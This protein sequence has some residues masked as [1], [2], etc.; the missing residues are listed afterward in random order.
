MAKYTGIAGGCGHEHT[1]VL[2][3]PA[4]ERQR[5]IEWFERDGLCAECYKAQLAREEEAR[6]NDPAVVRAEKKDRLRDIC[7][8]RGLDAGQ[9]LDITGMTR[10]QAQADPDAWLDATIAALEV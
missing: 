4:K 6:R 1:I 5:K 3:G 2:G 7:K 9:L 10:E 8:E